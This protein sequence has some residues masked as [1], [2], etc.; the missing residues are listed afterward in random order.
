MVLTAQRENA[1]IARNATGR[2]QVIQA[3]QQLDGSQVARGTENHEMARPRNRF[4]NAHI[5]LFS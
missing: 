2:F 5:V 1:H 3:R 4:L